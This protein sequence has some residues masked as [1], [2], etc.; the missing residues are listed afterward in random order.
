[1]EIICPTFKGPATIFDGAPPA[2]H[3]LF[4][5]GSSQS[6]RQVTVL[7]V[8]YI[9]FKRNLVRGNFVILNRIYW[10]KLLNKSKENYESS[11]MFYF[12]Q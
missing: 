4:G 8:Q 6:K 3:S 7:N 11:M 5:G 10:T 2:N 1:M 9:L 12:N